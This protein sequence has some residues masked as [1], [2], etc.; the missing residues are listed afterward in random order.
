MFFKKFFNACA[1]KNLRTALLYKV[2]H[3]LHICRSAADPTNTAR[4]AV[5][6]FIGEAGFCINFQACVEKPVDR[7]TDSVYI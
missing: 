1:R 2:E 4:F 7:R 5:L 6:S 3:Q